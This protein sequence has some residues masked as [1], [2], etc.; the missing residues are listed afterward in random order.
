MPPSISVRGRQGKYF[1]AGQSPSMP[2]QCPA[3]RTTHLVVRIG[4]T[5]EWR[6]LLIAVQIPIP[7]TA[8]TY[9]DGVPKQPCQTVSFCFSQENGKE[10]VMVFQCISICILY[11][12][13]WLTSRRRFQLHVIVLPKVLA[14][15][16][17][18][19]LYSTQMLGWNPATMAAFSKASCPRS[20]KTHKNM[21]RFQFDADSML[22]VFTHLVMF[23]KILHIITLYY[24]PLQTCTPEYLRLPQLFWTP[25]TA[26]LDALE[27]VTASACFQMAKR[28]QRI[29]LAFDP[30]VLSPVET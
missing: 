10:K 30:Q 29:G 21:Q 11:N 13:E 25:V 18:W 9:R 27:S 7:L 1:L 3:V 8:L 19:P 20:P 4:R 23:L 16:E 15:G 2:Q 26:S 22:T 28:F 12:V 24:M 6:H 17:R 14:H 5:S